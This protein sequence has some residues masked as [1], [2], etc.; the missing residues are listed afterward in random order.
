MVGIEGVPLEKMY[1]AVEQHVLLQACV[2]IDFGA[3]D[4]VRNRYEV[5][6]FRYPVWFGR[7]G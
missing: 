6:T 3:V 5:Q 1:R 4:E 2:K 7:Y